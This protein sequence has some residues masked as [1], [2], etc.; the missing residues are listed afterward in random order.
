MRIANDTVV[1]I[2]YTMHN[3]E[4]ELLDRTPSGRP[5]TYLHGHGNIVPGLEEALHGRAE[6]ERLSVKVPPEDGFGPY[7]EALVRDV[8]ASAFPESAPPEPGMRYDADTEAGPTELLV[9]EV[10]GDRVTIDA[11]P[12]FAGEELHFSLIV[13]AVREATQ[14]EIEHGHV[15]DARSVT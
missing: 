4:G 8:P 12:A 1:S 5:L 10:E 6:G 13:S 15:H 9:T 11:N 14:E 2:E 3:A 7:R